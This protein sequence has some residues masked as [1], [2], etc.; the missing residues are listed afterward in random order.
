[1]PTP[2]FVLALR[3]KVGT[4]LLWLTGV[5][6]VVRN[7]R[8]EVLLGRRVDTGEWALPSGILEPGEQP[9]LGLA[10]E[11][12]EETG[13]VVRVE[14]LASVETQQEQSYPNGDRAQSLDLCFL[15]RHVEGEARVNDDESLEVGWYA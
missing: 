3:D 7:D 15:A 2:D 10:R 9:A 5:S 12:E 11:I 13:V 1:M 4:D 8:G 14:A 6:A